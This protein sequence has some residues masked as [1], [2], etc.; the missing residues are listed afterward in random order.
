[1]KIG[2]LGVDLCYK[3][4]SCCDVWSKY[5]YFFLQTV[6]FWEWV[7]RVVDLFWSRFDYSSLRIA[8]VV[9]KPNSLGQIG[10]LGL[11][12]VRF[13]TQ[14][15]YRDMTSRMLVVTCLLEL[16]DT[17]LRNGI[18]LE[19]FLPFCH[20]FGPNWHMFVSL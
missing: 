20:S 3:T 6:T 18:H 5:K 8:Q 2:L 4:I 17:I 14:D 19:H 15:I 10:G 9:F 11:L 1:M 7:C 13:S 16:K 12:I